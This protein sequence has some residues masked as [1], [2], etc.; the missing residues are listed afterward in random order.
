[1]FAMVRFT[2]SPASALFHIFKT[3][4]R[5]GLKPVQRRILYAMN[6]LKLTPDSGFRKCA[7]V[8]GEVLGKYHPHGDVSVYEA[9]VRMAQ[10]F[11]MQYPLVHGHGQ[12]ELPDCPL[13]T[14]YISVSVCRQLWKYR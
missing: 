13:P 6:E 8:V 5:L 14:I 7:R 11:V 1:M 3:V 4:I 10:D 9:L 2:S 12:P